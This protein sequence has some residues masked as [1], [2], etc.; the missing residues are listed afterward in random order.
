MKKSIATLF[1]AATSSVAFAQSGQT[2]DEKLFQSLHGHASLNA[3]IVVA[4]IIVIGLFITLWRI[5]RKVAK[6]ENEMREKK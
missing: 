2:L 6:L 4:A 1:L 3:V 5:D